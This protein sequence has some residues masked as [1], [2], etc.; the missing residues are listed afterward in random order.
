LCFA[1]GGCEY[2]CG[3]VEDAGPGGGCKRTMGALTRS[4]RAE[5]ELQLPSS[6]QH[7]ILHT[8]K[9]HKNESEGGEDKKK[10]NPETNLRLHR[11]RIKMR[12]PPNPVIRRF[13]VGAFRVQHIV[14]RLYPA[15]RRRGRDTISTPHPNEK[16]KKKTTLT[17]CCPTPATALALL[18]CTPGPSWDGHPFSERIIFLPFRAGWFR[19]QLMSERIRGQAAEAV[20][21]LAAWVVG[22]GGK[23]ERG[24]D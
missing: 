6:A 4:L 3:W 14:I 12:E 9:N 5:R 23:G 17:S 7:T 24:G 16:R 19:A 21:A 8:R 1:C 13:E 20:L 11:I 2:G 15:K 10:K 22:R 18:A